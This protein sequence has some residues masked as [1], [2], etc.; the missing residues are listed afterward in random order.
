[1]TINNTE[2]PITPDSPPRPG[3]PP[4][5][6]LARKAVKRAAQAYTRPTSRLRLLP[7]YL[8]IGAQRAGTTSL[9]RYLVQHPAVKTSLRTKGVHFFDG[10]D[11][12][13]GMAWYASRFPSKP[14]RWY[15]RRRHGVD[16]ITGEASPYYVFHPHVP[17]RVAEHLPDVKL[18]LLLRD[19]VQRAY[20]HYQHELSRG[21]ETLSFDEAIEREPDRLAGE[22]ERMLAD[23]RY[24]SFSH[25]HYSY[26][27]RGLYAD[28]L[29]IWRSLFPDEQLLVLPSEQFFADPKATFGRVLDF[30][31]LPIFVPSG[32]EQHNAERYG[33]MSPAM[34]RRLTAYFAEP[35]QRLYQTLG[36]DFGW[37]S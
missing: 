9:H 20:S 30:L 2:Q 19:P 18:I 4:A 37:S 26:L 28:Q 10:D 29:A 27:A 12:G 25:R 21:Y 35:N 31:R 16:L 32:F 5:R 3:R 22:T 34:R 23:P 7:S 1:M 33:R 6:V 13:K 8:I 24:N 15:V 11:Y 17:S 36:Q 14:Y